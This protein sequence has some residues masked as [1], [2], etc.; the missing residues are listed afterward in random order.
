MKRNWLT[1]DLDG[2]EKTIARRGKSF[3]LGELVRNALDENG[4]THV[5]IQV[6]KITNRPAVLLDITDDA[7][8][9]F[10]DLAETYT[11][12]GESY[13]KTDPEKA[14]RFNVGDKLA[15]ALCNYAVITSTSGTVIFD[16]GERTQSR[17]KVDKGSRLQLEIKMN[18]AEYAELMNYAHKLIVP[19]SVVVTLN[20]ESLVRPRR[21]KIIT[22]G[23]ITEIANS[24]GILK[25][26]KRS[27]TVEV[28]AVDN[29]QR[30]VLYELGIPVMELEGKYHV[31]V[32][33][34]IPL[35]LERDAVP[36]SYLQQINVLLVNH[37]YQD[38][39]E[40]SASD[41]WVREATASSDILEPALEKV[42]DLRFGEKRVAF[43]PS[44]L[45]ASRK[46]VASGYT[47]VSGG[48][49]S[50]EEWKNVRDRDLIPAAGRVL[51]TYKPYNSSGMPA[52]FI[53]EDEWSKG[54]R[55]IADFINKLGWR[56]LRRR[57]ETRYEKGRRHDP[58]S[59]NYGAGILIFNYDKCGKKRFERGHR[60]HWILSTVIH[61]FGHEFGDHLTEKFDRA[62]SDLGASLVEL[63]LQEPEL[64]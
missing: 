2:L 44:D 33:Q 4:V 24:E 7:P 19:E 8:N 53:P 59:A 38:L 60:D 49:L 27:T 58:F 20:N 31:N 32:N 64:F 15:L 16:K 29:G 14:G 48:S 6:H 51:P 62:M 10:R 54:M 36:L 3:I 11:L 39:D 17:K 28:F 57:V 34:K 61:E 56:L 25:R 43:D 5:D 52:V 9:G 50:K 12:F 21:V 42:M 1:V 41:S 18:Q 23:L 37:L 26:V 46:A 22:A 40:V 13:K 30:A 35:T 45:E 63:A 47:V 55:N